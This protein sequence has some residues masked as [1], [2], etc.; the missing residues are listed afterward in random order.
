MRQLLHVR[1]KP[2]ARNPYDSPVTNADADSLRSAFRNSGARA[3]RVAAM[4]QGQPSWPLRIAALALALAA[5]TVFV[6]VVLPLAL[7]FAIA[8]LIWTGFARLTARLRALL[9]GRGRVATREGR[10]NVRVIRR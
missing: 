2:N 1:S 10:R 3:A 7:I 6:V 9:E 4:V 8:L 5:L